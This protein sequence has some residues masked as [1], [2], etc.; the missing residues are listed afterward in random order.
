MFCLLEKVEQVD[1][2][3]LFY[4]SC[5]AWKHISI[6][7]T[8]LDVNNQSFHTGPSVRKEGKV[9]RRYSTKA[10]IKDTFWNYFSLVGGDTVSVERRGKMPAVLI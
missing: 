4:K 5:W 6:K 9:I 8:D 2:L 10:L 3:Q 7:I 1:T